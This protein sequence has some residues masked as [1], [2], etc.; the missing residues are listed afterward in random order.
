[1]NEVSI[2]TGKCPIRSYYDE[3]VIWSELLWWDNPQLGNVLVTIIIVK[4]NSGHCKLS[5]TIKSGYCELC[6]Q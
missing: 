6:S 5:L 4:V 1:M 2:L 3:S